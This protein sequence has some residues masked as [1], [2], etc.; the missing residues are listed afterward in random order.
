MQSV[1]PLESI[2]C[3]G[4]LK[5]RPFRAPDYAT[6]SHA[7]VALAR[8]LADAPASS[9][10]TLAEKILEVL[11]VGSAGVSLLTENGEDFFWPAIAGEWQRHIGGGTPRNF[12]PCGDVLDCNAPLLFKRLERR[13]AYF[14]PVTPPVEECLLVPF[15]IAGKAVG[16]IWA[17]AHDN[18]RK[19]DNE[20]LRQ[21]ENLGRFASAAYQAQ[22]MGALE[23]RHATLGL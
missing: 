17:I 2:L 14:E 16:T 1:A 23:E 4:E 11:K 6:E 3:T 19:F 21:L 12:G 15:Y 8:S 20:D 5:R 7:L 13:Y 22:T 9:L 18:L 10:Q